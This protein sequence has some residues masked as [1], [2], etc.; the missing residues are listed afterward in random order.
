MVRRW[1][2]RWLPLLLWLGAIYFL[3]AQPKS[4]IP[5]FG[6]W[7]LL[8]KKGAHFLAYGVLAGLAW[9]AFADWSRPY[10]WA[11]LLTVL[12]AM[13]DEYHQTFVPGRNGA[14]ADVIIDSLGGLAALFILRKNWFR[15][16]GSPRQSPPSP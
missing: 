12:Y 8:I 5:S 6:F 15:F 7:D 2:Y 9:R 1:L 3:S 10:H 14:L 16:P 13:S 11:M 4:D